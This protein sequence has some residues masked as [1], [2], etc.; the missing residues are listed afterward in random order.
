MNATISNFSQ[1]LAAYVTKL[2]NDNVVVVQ[3]VDVSRPATR[4]IAACKHCKASIELDLTSQVNLSELDSFSRS[5]KHNGDCAWF[6]DI[7]KRAVKDED[8]VSGTAVRGN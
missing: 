2:S 1:L 7:C 4:N 3:Q 8:A 5:H 6:L